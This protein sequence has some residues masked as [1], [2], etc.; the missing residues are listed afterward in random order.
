MFDFIDSYIEKAKPA[1]Q[2]IAVTAQAYAERIISRLDRIAEAVESEEYDEQRRQYRLSLTQDIEQDLAQIPTGEEWFLEA[3]SVLTTCAVAINESGRFKFAKQFAAA[4][5]TSPNVPF[6][7]GN[8][9]TIVSTGNAAPVEAFVQFK[10]KRK[11]PAKRTGFAGDVVRAPNGLGS[12][13]E[14]ENERRHSNDALTSVSNVIGERATH[15]GI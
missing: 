4:D 11:K 14:R 12:G 10:V 8:T 9:L 1:A 6:R 5:F 13:Q 2:N 15:R 3:V 7:G